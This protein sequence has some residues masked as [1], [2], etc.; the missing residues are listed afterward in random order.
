[1][2]ARTAELKLVVE[3]LDEA[4]EGMDRILLQHK[5]YVA[6][7]SA[8]AESGSAHMVVASLRVPVDQFDV[9]LAELKKLG[10]VTQESQAGEEVTQQHM[11]LLA[12]LKNSRNTEVRLSEVLRQH[13]G[14]IKEILDV[15]KESARVRGEIEQLEAEQQTLE[16]RV[17]FATIELKLAE[18]FEAQ[19]STPS[20]SVRSQLRNAGVNGFRSA[21]QSLLAVVLF[22]AESGPSL[23]LW[24]MILWF[25]GW[26]LWRRYRRSLRMG[27]QAAI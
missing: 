3:K 6:N 21:F 19:L 27:S 9:C 18:E 5:G 7:L 11:D 14:P 4:R 1:M 15:E 22:L 20:P 17:H 16:H 25:P 12:R 26:L 24:L 2:I 8:S 10:H 23:L 13:N